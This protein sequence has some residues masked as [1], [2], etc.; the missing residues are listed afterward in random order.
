[1]YVPL[2]ATITVLAVFILLQIIIDTRRSRRFKAVSKQLLEVGKQQSLTTISVVIR[3]KN[4][5]QQVL[6]LLNHLASFDYDKLQVVVVPRSK[7]ANDSRYLT[8]YR[9]AHPKLD[10]RIVRSAGRRDDASIAKRHARGELVLWL[11]STERLAARFF[12]RASYEFANPLINKVHVPYRHQSAQSVAHLVAIWSS[13]RA[14]TID[15]TVRKNPR[16]YQ[17]I[18]RRT[19]FTRSATPRR[20]VKAGTPIAVIRPWNSSNLR[21]ILVVS[22]NVLISAVLGFAAIY[23]L[24]SEWLFT[25]LAVAIAYLLSNLFWLASS[26]RYSWREATVLIVALPFAVLGE[27]FVRIKRS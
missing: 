17:V 20:V 26:K 15:A 8:D 22:A 3:E 2:V 9:A 14:E 16:P 24:S 12:E 4:G 13:V 23:Y 19:L 25:V 6:D 27:S 5:K 18:Y 10:I 21:N 7:K 11:D 1:M